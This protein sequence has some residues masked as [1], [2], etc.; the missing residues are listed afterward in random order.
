L[1]NGIV[2]KIHS[3]FQNREERLGHIIETTEIEILNEIA[4]RYFDLLE[5]SN[6]V[7]LL[8]SRI[9]IEKEFL[10][11]LIGIN[12]KKGAIKMNENY[13]KKINKLQYLCDDFT[14]VQLAIDEILENNEGYDVLLFLDGLYRDIIDRGHDYNL[15]KDAW[16][17]Y[18]FWTEYYKMANIETQNEDSIIIIE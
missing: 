8:K 14:G 15:T 2:R 7:D 13:I 10:E 3:E 18:K 9:T 11:K 6:I 17:C 16:R 12:D 4:S 1:V 5:D